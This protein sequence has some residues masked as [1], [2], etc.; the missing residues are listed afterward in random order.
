MHFD[1]KSSCF[2][3]CTLTQLTKS[4]PTKS[5]YTGNRFFLSLA[6]KAV[7][8]I[9][10]EWMAIALP[11]RRKD[12]QTLTERQKN[13]LSDRLRCKVSTHP[14][15]LA[16]KNT[17][18]IFCTWSI[19]ASATVERSALHLNPQERWIPVTRPYFYHFPQCHPEYNFFCA[20]ELH[21]INQT[22]SVFQAGFNWHLANSGSPK[23]ANI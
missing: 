2:Y 9:H 8:N 23:Y 1:K 12:G 6:G 5:V 11:S 13:R 18:T 21:E 3:V 15:E 10:R 7:A 14:I 22:V 19:T 17:Y 16:P 20:S 4:Y